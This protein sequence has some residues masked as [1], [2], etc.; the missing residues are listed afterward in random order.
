MRVYVLYFV[1]R[2]VKLKSVHLRQNKVYK[3]WLLLELYLKQG[4]QNAVNI[5]TLPSLYILRTKKPKCYLPPQQR[6]VYKLS[7]RTYTNF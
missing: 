7:A 3:F 2:Y 6:T 1:V 4:G 5:K